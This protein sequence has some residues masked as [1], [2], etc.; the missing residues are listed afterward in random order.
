ML[1]LRSLPAVKIALFLIIG[2]LMGER[3]SGTSL[4][5][6]GLLVIGLIIVAYFARNASWGSAIAYGVIVFTGIFIISS[7][8]T[9]L[10]IFPREPVYCIGKITSHQYGNEHG[11]VY[12][13]Q[14]EWYS[15]DGFIKYPIKQSLRLIN[16]ADNAKVNVGDRVVLLG[17]I[18]AYPQNRNSLETDWR[19][20]FTGLGISGWIKPQELSVI[21]SG[22][23][24]LLA[25]IRSTI[26]QSFLN[27]LPPRHA[28]LLIG[29]VLGEKQALPE[30]IENDF[31][32]SGFYHILSVSGLHLGFMAVLLGLLLPPIT[33]SLR[34]RRWLLLICIWLYTMLT[35][36]NAATVRAA[37]MLT[38]YLLSYDLQRVPQNW[39]LLGAAA[40]IIL[41]YAPRQL[42]SPGF[43]LSFAATAG[44]F[45]ALEVT[46]TRQLKAKIPISSHRIQGIID[47]Y[48]LTPALVSL[49]AVLFTAPILMYHFSSFAPASIPMNILA[50]PLSGVVFSLAWV[51]LLIYSLTNMTIYPVIAALELGLLGLEKLAF[52]GSPFS[53]HLPGGAFTALVILFAFLGFL[54][55]Q[56]WKQRILWVFASI[57]LLIFLSASRKSPYLQ[58]ECLDVGQGDATLLRFPGDVNLLV[59]CGT[60]D[61]AKHKL[62][63]V[64]QRQGVTHLNGLLLSH[65]DRDH[66][67]GAVEL[68]GSFKIGRL[69]VSSTH[70]VSQLGTEI[71]AAAK[72]RNIPIQSLSLGDTLSGLSSA[73]GVVLWPPLEGDGE[74]NLESIVVRISYLETDILLTGDVSCDQEKAIECAGNY[75]QSEVLK[76]SHHGSKSASEPEFLQRVKPQIALISVG[77]HN[78]YHH[79]SDQVLTEL[80]RDNSQIY[81]TDEQGSITFASDGKSIW[82][83][84]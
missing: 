55:T 21:S 50:I 15:P 69:L 62:I 24:G 46:S 83:I 84:K 31:R 47:N 26:E 36:C 8:K 57:V 67:G 25:Q 56:G 33:S 66:C 49:F 43:Q 76:I 42:F 10:S 78:P 4:L 51:H 75:L 34:L 52:L 17:E 60:G 1:N 72:S 20:I 9:A 82:Q 35:G 64:L 44:V 39:N 18:Q 61:A 12:N 14:V 68:I 54:F 29:M 3:I 53:T 40:L 32:N 38:L 5:F 71:I 30:D 27:V 2:I 74:E 80:K 16:S 65:Y 81:R 73:K 58:I 13:F 77:K 7:S 63:P 6:V 19:K 23:L 45:L 11:E 28:G 22:S 79:P 37:I 70:P 48:F 59:D 41:A